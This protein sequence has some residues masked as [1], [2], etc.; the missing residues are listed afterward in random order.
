MSKSGDDISDAVT[1]LLKT[2]KNLDE[3]DARTLVRK[4]GA[5]AVLNGIDTAGKIDPKFLNKIGKLLDDPT[6]L[7]SLTAQYDIVIKNRIDEVTSGGKIDAM[8]K[9][10]GELVRGDFTLDDIARVTNKSTDEIAET[11]ARSDVQKAASTSR[12][13]LIKLG[14]SG[15]MV[16]GVVFLMIMTGKT[17]PVEAIAEALKAAAETAADTGGDIFQKLFTGGIGGLFNVSA[18]FLFCSSVGLVLWLVISVVLKK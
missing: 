10:N 16:A 3:V 1:R 9:K 7:K 13:D 6:S 15:S 18:M 12:K 4:Y 8:F 5:K 11:A 14:I 17:N 2:G